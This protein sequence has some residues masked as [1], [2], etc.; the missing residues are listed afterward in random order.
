MTKHFV[1]LKYAAS[2][3]VMYP[4]GMVK[5]IPA[6]CFE[7][8]YDNCF[9]YRCMSYDQVKW[10]IPDGIIGYAGDETTGVINYNL[11]FESIPNDQYGDMLKQCAGFNQYATTICNWNTGGFHG[12]V[13]ML[14]QDKHNPNLTLNNF[15]DILNVK[16]QINER[17]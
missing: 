1:D 6:Y 2:A 13:I 4:N 15:Y 11:I 14:S 7:I 10:Y 12:P 9:G 5:L 16:S 8:F 17:N 3:V